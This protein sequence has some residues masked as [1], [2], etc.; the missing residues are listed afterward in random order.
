[1]IELS[2]RAVLRA[3]ALSAAAIPFA[4]IPMAHGATTSGSLYTRSRF[5]PYVNRTFT[6]TLGA[7]SWTATLTAVSDLAGAPAGAP[8]RF[9]LLFR[10]SS[11]G[12]TQETCTFSRSGFTATPLFVVPT[13]SISR[14]YVAVVNQA[15]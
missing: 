7:R 8:G 11:A 12:P 2:R 10:T 13:D 4:S 9:Q 15:P 1:M 14:V 3:G 5:T 6:M